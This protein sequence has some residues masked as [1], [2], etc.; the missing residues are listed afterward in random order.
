MLEFA[1]IP[2]TASSVIG[3]TLASNKFYSSKLFKS[4]DVYTPDFIAINKISELENI[5]LQFPILIKPNDEGSSRGI[6]QDSLVNTKEE[7]F[8]GV[9]KALELYQP[10]ILLNEYIV[11]REFS[12]GVIG[13]GKDIEVLPIQEVDLSN[14]PDN[15][16]KFYSFEVK[17][18]Y[19]EY[20][21]YHIPAK[22]SNEEE[23]LIKNACIKAYN[24]LNLKD[25]AR[26]DVI[27]KDNIPYVLEI[28]SLPGLMKNKSALYRM[29]ESSG[30]GYENFV[31]QIV[32]TAK[33]R[34][35]L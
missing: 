6:H 31:L 5:D 3:H 13:N 20:T 27:L 15:L 9:K 26:V 29:A 21:T 7:L 23:L 2:Y 35:N 8:D 28:N 18:Y 30:Q 1:G 19:K 32:D 11:G 17:T 16:E 24:T 14:L 25:Y 4:N 10:P 34:Y 12:V 33:L 22:L